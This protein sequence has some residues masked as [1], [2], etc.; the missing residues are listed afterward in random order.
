M[1][2]HEQF[3]VLGAAVA[4]ELGQHLQDLPEN[5]ISQRG[6]HDRDHH[7]EDAAAGGQRRT[8]AARAGFTSRTGCCG[9]DSWAPPVLRSSLGLSPC[10]S[11]VCNQ[12]GLIPAIKNYEPAIT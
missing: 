5:L 11:A 7:G 1:S 4:G 2:E 12:D 3:D 6:V 9:V 8:S 10:R